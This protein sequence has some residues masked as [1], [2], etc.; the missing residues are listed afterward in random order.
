MIINKERRIR[1]VVVVG[2]SAGGF[3]SIQ[4][5]AAA[6]P[7]DLPAGIAVALH[8]GVHDDP[9]R[10]AWIL[11]QGSRLRVVEPSGGE[12][13][14]HGSLYVAPM[15][16][17]LVFH[18]GRFYV[19]HG[20]KE[21]F[22]RPAADP[23]FRSVADELGPRV[24]AVVLS[25]YDGDGAMGARAVTAA[26]G[27]TLVQAPWEAAVPAMPQST[28]EIDHVAG[29]LPLDRLFQAVTALARGEPLVV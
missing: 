19:S 7:A 28:I 6:F 4:A 15:D 26:G 14:E 29:A 23:L 10:L 2:A 5:M 20:P 9:G 25:G 13:F 18:Q 24:L 22:T 1:D 8:R 21:H 27:I 17:H 16:R 12:P 11:Q 3:R